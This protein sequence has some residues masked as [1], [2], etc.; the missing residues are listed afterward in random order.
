[1][2]ED[3]K[4][5][6]CKEIMYECY[7]DFDKIRCKGKPLTEEEVTSLDLDYVYKT[8]AYAKT[9]ASGKF[10]NMVQDDPRSITYHSSFFEK[11]PEPEKDDSGMIIN[12]E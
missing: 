1:M 4:I 2:T 7:Y 3:W 5:N 9:Y 10:K 8:L 11:K 6:P 12:W